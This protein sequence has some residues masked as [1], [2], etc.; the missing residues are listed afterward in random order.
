M[1]KYAVFAYS[2]LLAA[3]LLAAAC[4]TAAKP[5]P[6]LPSTQPAVEPEVVAPDI[7]VIS[8]VAEWAPSSKG[9]LQCLAENSYGGTL[10]YIWSV[11]GGSIV[12]DG[13]RA[14]WT[15]PDTEGD[16]TVTVKVTNDR[17]GEASL[18]RTFKVTAHPFGSQP[19]DNAVYL[20]MTLPGAETVKASKRVMAATITEI[21]CVIKDAENS[22]LTYT[23]SLEAGRLMGVNIAEGKAS[24]AGWLAPGTPGTYAVTV[25]VSDTTGLQATGQV[26]FDVYLLNQ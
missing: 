7:K 16:Y 15:T 11:D 10:T 8:G 13:K 26:D 4:T 21:K 20:N 19:E 9:Q 14:T 23:W 22:V 2:L 5:E 6:Q 1:N 25:K 18:S 17:G 24:Q 3:V 12:G